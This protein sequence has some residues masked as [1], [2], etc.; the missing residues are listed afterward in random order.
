MKWPAPRDSGCPAPD[1]SRHLG[2]SPQPRCQMPVRP[3]HPPA[4]HNLRLVTWDY[5]AG[6]FFVTLCAATR[7]PVFGWITGG[8]F[9]PSPLGR[10]VKECWLSVPVIHPRCGLDAFA[11]MPDHF[12]AIVHLSMP[13]ERARPS[14]AGS[15]GTKG[16]LGTII[17]QFK[18]AVTLAARHSRI[19]GPDSLWQRGYFERIVR[20]DR[21]LATVREYIVRNALKEAIRIGTRAG[22]GRIRPA[23]I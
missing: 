15:T 18:R 6:T 19:V 23:M 3:A 2:E 1:I 13:A 5:R 9:L 12:H 17:N 20:D 14:L 11:L 8:S 16:G 21:M 7:D 4:R 10:L 22:G